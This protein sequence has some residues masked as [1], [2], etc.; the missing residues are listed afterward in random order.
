MRH[1]QRKRRQ[2]LNNT[3]RIPLEQ[4]S[5]F[6]LYETFYETGTMLGGTL[7]ALE[8]KADREKSE[9]SLQ[10]WRKERIQLQHERDDMRQ[11]DRN[12]QI[13]LI[14]KWTDRRNRLASEI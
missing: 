5:D 13:A 14:R 10:H 11:S 12:G 9:S 1:A 3:E 7:V 6:A 8:D 4:L 2:A